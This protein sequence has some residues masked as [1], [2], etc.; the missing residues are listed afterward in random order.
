MVFLESVNVHGDV[1]VKAVYKRKNEPS[2]GLRAL[3][4]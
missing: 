3:N 4:Q 2:E 1:R